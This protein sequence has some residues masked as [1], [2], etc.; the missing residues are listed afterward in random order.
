MAWTS[1]KSAGL[2]VGLILLVIFIVTTTFFYLRRRSRVP[3]AEAVTPEKPTD[4][5][6]QTP[7]NSNQDL[8]SNTNT[9]SANDAESRT[10]SSSRASSSPSQTVQV[11]TSVEKDITQP[12]P[13]IVAEPPPPT[14]TVRR[15]TGQPQSFS[16]WVN[17]TNGTELPN[18][19]S[20]NKTNGS[21]LPD[22][23]FS[24]APQ[25][26]L[27]PKAP[28]HSPFP[29]LSGLSTAIRNS[30]SSTS[31]RPIASRAG[32]MVP[33]QLLLPVL[34]SPSAEAA[35]LMDSLPKVSRAGERPTTRDSWGATSLRR[36]VLGA[37]ENRS[38]TRLEKLEGEASE[39]EGFVE[40]RDVVGVAYSGAWP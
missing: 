17:E 34:A 13:A 28:H 35:K 7:S 26:T 36:A 31:L 16:D 3:K 37:G 12:T 21:D 30:S 4:I 39:D 6:S 32:P 15:T 11:F 29:S 19:S 25:L 8:D 23:S 5:E 27:T 2:A 9:N 40:G 14:G 1:S 10:S 22:F 33:P 18:F 38:V 24:D 20:S